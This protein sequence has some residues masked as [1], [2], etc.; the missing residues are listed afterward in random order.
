MNVHYIEAI[1]TNENSTMPGELEVARRFIPAEAIQSLQPYGNG[2]IN[3]TFLIE[4]KAGDRRIILQRVN[5]RVFHHPEWI[6]ENMRSLSGHLHRAA[7]P[8]ANPDDFRLAQILPAADGKNHF[9]DARGDYWRAQEFIPDSMTIETIGNTAQAEEV[10]LALGRF[11]ALVHD[12]DPAKL[13][14]T[15]PGFHD[16]PA[17]FARFLNASSRPGRG[18]AN[19]GL[20]GAIS[21]VEKRWRFTRVLERAKNEGKLPVRP[22][23]G[24][25]KL[26]NF[27]FDRR[28]GKAISLIDLDTVQP[29][30]IH[31]DVGD[32]LRSCANTVGES[33]E[34]LS[35]VRFDLDIARAILK[36]Y[37]SA[38]RGFLTVQDY[39]Y[40][41]DAIRL[42]PFELGLRFLTDHLE[43]DGYFKTA[44]PGQNLHR[45]L[46]QFQLATS[47][48][49]QERPLRQLLADL[50][51]V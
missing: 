21:F 19:A 42:I 17:Y 12:L 20:L 35:G 26:N 14:R 11:H 46:V 15:L 31:F 9:I 33:P 10:G 51:P 37:F 50:A 44:W 25:T 1:M 40:L 24:D 43:G 2:L 13:R 16:A 4:T 41:Y 3:D 30:L 45:A 6:M 28:S 47:I 32:C 36:G 48:E 23:H 39:K 34:D 38:A 27:L 29:G 22:V 18:G 5:R 7:V 8:G 49:T